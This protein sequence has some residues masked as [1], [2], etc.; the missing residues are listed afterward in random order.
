[1]PVTIVVTGG[2]DEVARILASYPDIKELFEQ[3]KLEE[4]LQKVWGMGYRHG[5]EVGNLDGQLQT[6]LR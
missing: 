2:Q 6:R 3:G 4:L 1:M 5:L